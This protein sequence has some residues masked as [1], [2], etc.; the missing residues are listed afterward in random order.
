MTLNWM[1]QFNGSN[2]VCVMTEICGLCVFS[3][4][5]TCVTDERMVYLMTSVDRSPCVVHTHTPVIRS[6][7]SYQTHPLKPQ[8]TPRIENRLLLSAFQRPVMDAVN[9]LT[10]QCT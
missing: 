5:G 1:D 9:I 4:V 6:G 2:S 3:N 8:S 7:I 10:L